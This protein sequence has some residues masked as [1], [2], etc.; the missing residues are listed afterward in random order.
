M[1]ELDARISALCDEISRCNS[2]ISAA[3]NL[4][5]ALKRIA[6]KFTS[7]SGSLAAGGFTIDGVGADVYSG[8]GYGEYA[9]TNISPIVKTLD[10]LCTTLS[11]ALVRYDKELTD[12]KNQR[13]RLLRQK[14]QDEENKKK[15]SNK[16]TPISKILK[17]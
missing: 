11:N 4:S 17:G 2:M 15:K 9:S 12:L 10:D 5:A 8:F 6:D 1:Y 13:D 7:C 16:T 14:Q 3:S